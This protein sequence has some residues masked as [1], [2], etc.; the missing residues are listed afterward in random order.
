MFQIKKGEGPRHP[1][2]IAGFSSFCNLITKDNITDIT[3]KVNHK[4][5]LFRLYSIWLFLCTIQIHC[6]I[7]LHRYICTCIT[8]ISSLSAYPLPPDTSHAYNLQSA[9]MN[10]VDYPYSRKS[11]NHI[12][13]YAQ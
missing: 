1:P 13:R 12:H 3:K 8:L 10:P 9:S 7:F 5:S 4:L 2:P 11:H 6:L